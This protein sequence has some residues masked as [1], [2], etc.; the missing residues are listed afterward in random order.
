MPEEPISKQD[1]TIPQVKELL[2]SLG[3]E[4]LTQFQ[5]RALDFASKF[6]KVD[7]ENAQNLVEELVKNFDLD[8]EEA[9]QVVNCMPESIEEVKVFLGGGR[10]IIAASKLKA[11]VKLLSTHRKLK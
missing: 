7:A 8:E 6:S 9:V 4:N 11:I 2:E 5:R 10:K 3:E 1:L